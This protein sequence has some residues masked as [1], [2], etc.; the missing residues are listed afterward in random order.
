[1]REHNMDY[2]I[3][4]DIKNIINK[5]LGL[6]K[7]EESLVAQEKSYD[8]KTEYLS[9]DNK[10]N[11]IELYEQYVK[12]FNKISAE[13]DAVDRL[14]ANSNYSKFRQLK[15]DETYNMN[16][17]YLHELYFSNISDVNSQIGMDSLSYMRLARDFG[18]F[19]DWQRDFMACCASSRCGW[20]VTY[21]NTYT[22][23]YM[24][25][26]IDLHSDSIPAGFYPIIVMDVWQHAYYRDYLKN[27]KL[28]TKAMMKELNWNVIEKRIEKADRILAIIRG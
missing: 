19:D 1:M 7:L 28:Y 14:N 24:N 20:A 27:N 26:F 4:K 17:A 15:I 23:K 18:N 11:H 9:S 22:Q 12:D 3:N 13:L 25:T 2:L 6:D 21:L 5:D 10:K 16:A 8:L